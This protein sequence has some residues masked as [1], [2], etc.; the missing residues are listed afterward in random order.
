MADTHS[1]S[2]MDPPLRYPVYGSS[3]PEC[4]GSS[5]HT[6]SRIQPTVYV[7]PYPA[8]HIRRLSVYDLRQARIRPAV[9]VTSVL[10]V[11]GS[12]PGS[13]SAPVRV[14]GSVCRHDKPSLA[15]PLPVGRSSPHPSE[16]CRAVR[17]VDAS[18]T[19]TSPLPFRFP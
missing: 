13:V 2:V 10:G 3:Y 8:S 4:W 14:S 17:T 1:F 5:L 16:S 19:V 12:L 18:F 15:A 11:Y 7:L 6:A 9:S